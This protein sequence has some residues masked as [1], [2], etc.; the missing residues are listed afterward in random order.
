MYNET[1]GG[2]ELGVFFFFFNEEEGMEKQG[3]SMNV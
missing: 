1:T 3:L 2:V